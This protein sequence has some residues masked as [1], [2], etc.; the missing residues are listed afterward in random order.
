MKY[1]KIINFSFFI[2]PVIRRIKFDTGVEAILASRIYTWHTKTYNSVHA[3][4][5]QHNRPT[6]RLRY[7]IQMRLLL[8]KEEYA[9]EPHV[10]KK[11]YMNDYS[12]HMNYNTLI[13][14]YTCSRCVVLFIYLSPSRSIFRSPRFIKFS[15]V[16]CHELESKNIKI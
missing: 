13:V 5:S 12:V 7:E 14:L 6:H 3:I 1:I 16:V 8:V 15:H 11:M 4:K 2:F 10:E 9:N